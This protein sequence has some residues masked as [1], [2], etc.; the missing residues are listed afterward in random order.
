[1][2]SAIAA[3]LVVLVIP[4]WTFTV[5]ALFVADRVENIQ[6]NDRKQDETLQRH[7]EDLAVLKSKANP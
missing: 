1:L 6:E 4:L 3:L 2:L 7:G 5:K